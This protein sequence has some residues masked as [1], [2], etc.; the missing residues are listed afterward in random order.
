MSRGQVKFSKGTSKELQEKVFRILNRNLVDGVCKI[1]GCTDSFACDGDCYWVK[2][3]LCSN[4]LA[5]QK[6]L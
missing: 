5:Q 3:N 1:C 6:L 2:P 4:C